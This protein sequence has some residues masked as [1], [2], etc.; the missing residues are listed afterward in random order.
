MNKAIAVCG[1]GGVGKTTIA[2]LMCKLLL[3]HNN[4]KGLAIDADPGAGLSQ[5]TSLPIKKTVNDLREEII[6]CSQ[7]RTADPSNL[8]AS[9]DYQLMESLTEHQ[10]LAFLAVGRPEE[11]GCYCQVNTF[12][13]EAIQ[14][15]VS[16][17]DY[18][19]ID[20]EA[21]IEQLNRRVMER[22]D[23]LMLVSDLSAKGLHVAK[24]IR[25]V[26][27]KNIKDHAVGL[28]LN[29]VK[30]EKEVSRIEQSIDLPL[31][32]WI[33]EDQNVNDFDCNAK[34]FLHFP[35]A[36]ALQAS[37]SIFARLPE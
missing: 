4:I 20:A 13:R 10:N 23:F 33:P 17:F 25:D 35:E 21:G 16:H 32:G 28:V 37:R 14:M 11:D 24:T 31:L 18:T 12:L 2:A 22:I 27:A 7:E 5:A 8:A 26:G 34:S 9:I 29:R 1:K 6:A 15:L 3:E 30:E 36:P 19:I